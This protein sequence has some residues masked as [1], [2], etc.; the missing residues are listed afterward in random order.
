MSS[1]PFIFFAAALVA[2]A[3]TSI[4]VWAPRRLPLKVSAIGMAA[5]FMPLG[6][7]GFSDLLS[8][9][10]PVSL[11]WWLSQ[12]DEAT[13]LGSQIRERDTVYLWLQLASEPEPRAYRMPWDQR[14]AEELQ[15]ALAEAQRNGTGVKMRLPFESTL[16]RRE[17][18]FY[19]LPQPA[20]P[21]KDLTDPPPEVYVQPGDNA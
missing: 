1:L 2:A 17:R 7:V 12:A 9:P 13:V 5:L 19:A 14:V 18:M 15:A 21:P 10:K 16:D 6:Y 20:L 11:E 3:L 4:A 8:R